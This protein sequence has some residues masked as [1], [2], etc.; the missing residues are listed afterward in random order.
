M[1]PIFEPEVRKIS[2]SDFKID[3]DLRPLLLG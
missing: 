2:L 3:G 1:G